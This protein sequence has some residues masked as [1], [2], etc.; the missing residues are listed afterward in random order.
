MRTDLSSQTL[1]RFPGEQ[2]DRHV[3]HWWIVESCSNIAVVALK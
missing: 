2:L 1:T 3:I